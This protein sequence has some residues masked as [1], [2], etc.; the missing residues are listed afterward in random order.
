MLHVLHTFELSILSSRSMRENIFLLHLLV[1][2]KI[3]YSVN[4]ELTNTYW[5]NTQCQACLSYIDQE[6]LKPIVHRLFGTC[7]SPLKLLRVWGVNFSHG[8]IPNSDQNDGSTDSHELWPKWLQRQLRWKLKS[9]GPWSGVQQCSQTTGACEHKCSLTLALDPPNT[10]MVILCITQ[11]F[12]HS[13][14]CSSLER[15]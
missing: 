6:Y 11:F 10:L 5:E 3:F 15:V 7:G 4:I 2:F 13:G 14:L 9:Q 12:S 8:H 1:F